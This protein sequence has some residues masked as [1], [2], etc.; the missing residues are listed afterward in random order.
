MLVKKS[1]E[2]HSAVTAAAEHST[3][4]HIHG[5]LAHHVA[6]TK[7]TAGAGKSGTPGHGNAAVHSSS[8]AWTAGSA[9]SAGSIAAAL[10]TRTDV[11]PPFWQLCNTDYLKDVIKRVFHAV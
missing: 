6:S 8:A 2:W 3:Q 10:P 5:D 11:K 4:L 9:G 1:L 7:H